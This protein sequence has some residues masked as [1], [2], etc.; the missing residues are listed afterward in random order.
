MIMQNQKKKKKKKKTVT[1]I[2]KL[3]IWNSVD[4]QTDVVTE[5]SH[6]KF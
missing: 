2:L 6:I 1:K 4:R 5:K 3:L